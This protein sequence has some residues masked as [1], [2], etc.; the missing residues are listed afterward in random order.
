MGDLTELMRRFGRL[1]T[2]HRKRMG[3][4]QAAL[5]DASGISVD[6]IVRIESGGTGVRFPNIQRLADSLQVDPAELF[7]S[8]VPHGKLERPLLSRLTT[9]LATLSDADLQLVTELIDVALKSRR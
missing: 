5:A 9:R 8:Q 7:T 1:V 2:A 3:M 6:M 4:T